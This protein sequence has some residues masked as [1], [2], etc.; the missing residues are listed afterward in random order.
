[1]QEVSNKDLKNKTISGVIWKGLERVVAQLV[2]AI[3]SIVLARI[4]IPD[5]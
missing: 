4:L 2:S 3:V 5:D 1:M